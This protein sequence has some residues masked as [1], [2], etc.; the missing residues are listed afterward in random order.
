MAG[1]CGSAI[2]ISIKDDDGVYQVVTGLRT[3]SIALNAEMVDITNASSVGKWREILDG[4]GLKSATIS[5]EGPFLNELG[6][7]ETVAALLS[8]AVRDAKILIPGF[9]TFEGPFKVTQCELSGEHTD[10]VMFSQTYESGGEVTFTA[11]S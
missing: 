7:T 5:G 6:Q 2:V 9:G 1:Q 10:A 3:Q 4:C 11:V 8:N